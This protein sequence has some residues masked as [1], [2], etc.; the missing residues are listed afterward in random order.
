MHLPRHTVEYQNGI[1]KFM[2]FAFSK[3]ARADTMGYK[4]VVNFY[5]Y[6]LKYEDG[7]Y[8]LQIY[9]GVHFVGW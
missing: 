7:D 9:I 3:S 5:L 2:E 6:K 4:T 1:K 8:L